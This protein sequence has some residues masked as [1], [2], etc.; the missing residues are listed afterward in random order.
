M[1]CGTLAISVSYLNHHGP[2]LSILLHSREILA[3]VSR[4]TSCAVTRLLCVVQSLPRRFVPGAWFCNHHRPLAPC[5]QADGEAE[6]ETRPVTLL[7]Q[8]KYGGRGMWMGAR[9][10]GTRTPS[11]KNTEMPYPCWFPP[12]NIPVCRLQR[13]RLQL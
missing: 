6:S 1:L 11:L 13:S 3:T 7:V 10:C 8:F 5:Y 12:R 9:R 2:N 4:R